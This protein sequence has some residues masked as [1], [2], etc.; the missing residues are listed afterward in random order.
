MKICS[1]YQALNMFVGVVVN[2]FERV[3]KFIETQMK[4]RMC[5]VQ[6]SGIL[7]RIASRKLELPVFPTADDGENIGIKHWLEEEEEEERP[8]YESYPPWRLTIHKVIT[9]DAF[10]ITIIFLTLI[11]LLM[12]SVEYYQMPTIISTVINYCSYFFMTL[13]ALEALFKIIA[14]GFVRYISERWNQIDLFIFILSTVG[15]ILEAYIP[16]N[17]TLIRAARVFRIARAFKLLKSAEGIRHLIDTIAKAIPHVMYLS[18]LFLLLFFVYAALAL[19]LYGTFECPHDSC[20][21]LSRHAS[22]K[23][24]G[25]TMLTL[26]RIFTGDNWNAI[27]KDM[28]EIAGNTD[29][30]HGFIAKSPRAIPCPI[31]YYV[32]P[33]YFISF[34]LLTQFFLINIVVAVLMR[35]LQDQSKAAELVAAATRSSADAL[36][37]HSIERAEQVEAALKNNFAEIVSSLICLQVALSDLT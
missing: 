27:L 12:M 24:F 36:Q 10:E 9:H 2:N 15:I 30:C 6:M 7:A 19:Q 20:E 4:Q 13:M 1:E 21:G 22:F 35:N 18:A 26:F 25:L 17:P 5:S 33:V 16:I 3:Q 23:N 28:L 14:F 32:S 31:I 29:I 34:V 11:N 8:Y 37:L